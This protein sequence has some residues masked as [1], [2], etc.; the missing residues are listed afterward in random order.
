MKV[1]VVSV[2]FKAIKSLKIFTLDK[3]GCDFRI[4][5]FAHI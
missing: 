4:L 2:V 5:F 3:K 1:V